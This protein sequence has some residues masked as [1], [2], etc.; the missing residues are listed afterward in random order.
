[1]E[2]LVG[3]TFNMALLDSGCTKTVCGEQWLK[4]F[5]DTLSPND[6]S[7]IIT[8]KSN[9]VF[10]FGE[11]KMIKSNRCV[12]IPVKIAETPVILSTDVI[13]YDIPLLLS[14]EAMKKAKTQIDQN[15]HGF[16]PNQFV[17]GKNPSFPNVFDNELP[18][19][20]R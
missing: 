19:L 15:V 7:S 8:E 10:K 6:V 12:K 9:T 3:K 17:F 11:N 5:L 2:K 14:K 20:D 16:S 1:M 13:D 18:A 4:V